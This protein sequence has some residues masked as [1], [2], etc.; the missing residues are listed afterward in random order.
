MLIPFGF[1]KS[2]IQRTICAVNE[3]SADLASIFSVFIHP[4][5]IKIE[6]EVY[7]V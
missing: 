3:Q 1:L 5:A 4:L 7:I 6:A 2:L